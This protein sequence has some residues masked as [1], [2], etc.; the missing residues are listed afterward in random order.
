MVVEL[1]N[2]Q[3]KMKMTATNRLSALTGAIAL[4]TLANMAPS[5]AETR[6]Y[7]KIAATLRGYADATEE[8]VEGAAYRAALYTDEQDMHYDGRVNQ[9]AKAAAQILATVR[10]NRARPDLIFINVSASLNRVKGF[11]RFLCVWESATNR[12]LLDNCALNASFEL[13]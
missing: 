13:V 9:R 7:K 4:D 10:L 12:L 3:R 6:E 2:L 11:S 1:A 5:A 8:R